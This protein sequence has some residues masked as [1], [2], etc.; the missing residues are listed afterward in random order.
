MRNVAATGFW[1][2]KTFQ[3]FHKL[4]KLSFKKIYS[5]KRIFHVN[6]IVGVPER[7]N[8]SEWSF[9]IWF[10]VYDLLKQKSQL[11]RTILFGSFV[12]RV[13][14]GPGQSGQNLSGKNLVT[15]KEHRVTSNR[16]TDGIFWFFGLRELRDVKKSYKKAHENFHAQ[17]HNCSKPTQHA[18]KVLN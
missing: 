15:N 18:A 1:N 6:R 7:L 4:W 10:L 14:E 8:L 3:N 16:D 12:W 17:K 5:G 2:L 11:D 9:R 13:P